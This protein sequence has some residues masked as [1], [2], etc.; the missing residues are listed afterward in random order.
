[1][2]LPPSPILSLVLRAPRDLVTLEAT[3]LYLKKF[4]KSEVLVFTDRPS[5]ELDALLHR[6]DMPPAH[7]VKKAPPA[8]TLNAVCDLAR[9]RLLLFLSST[10]VPPSDLEKTLARAHTAVGGTIAIAQALSFPWKAVWKFLER[11][12]HHL[13]GFLLGREIL[14]VDRMAFQREGGFT[15]DRWLGLYAA[16]LAKLEKRGKIFH[17]ETPP[18]YPA[19]PSYWQIFRLVPK[20]GFQLLQGSFTPAI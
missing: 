9:G 11:T 5:R 15:P 1:M 14:F 19:P 16:C 13:P 20:L 8:Q 7:I 18:F 3:L 17:L 10:W 4:S 6:Y 2:P 12:S